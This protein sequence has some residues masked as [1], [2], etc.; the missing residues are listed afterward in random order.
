MAGG[1]FH[2]VLHHTYFY[3]L[4]PSISSI[5]CFLNDPAFNLVMVIRGADEAGSR[6]EE[7]R[8]RRTPTF[9]TR[10]I[11]VR[12]VESG[13]LP[14]DRTDPTLSLLYQLW[15]GLLLDFLEVF[16][17][18]ICTICSSSIICRLFYLIHAPR[19]RTVSLGM[20]M[21]KC[22]N[23]SLSQKTLFNPHPSKHKFIKTPNL[24]TSSPGSIPCLALVWPVVVLVTPPLHSPSTDRS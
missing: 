21:C 11:I 22:W 17:Y 16:G 23:F 3:L 24:S 1:A 4:T 10:P 15:T 20:K 9:A 14:R 18:N 7:R 12:R 13:K 19:P 6:S 5:K 2:Q 8:R